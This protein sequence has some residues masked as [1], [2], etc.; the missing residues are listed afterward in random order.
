MM[1]AVILGYLRMNSSGVSGFFMLVIGTEHLKRQEI[2][3]YGMDV[4]R[5]RL[6]GQMGKRRKK[7]LDFTRL[8]HDGILPSYIATI[9]GIG[10]VKRSDVITEVLCYMPE[11]DY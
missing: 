11:E 10:N 8:E 7:H 1:C 9:R 3:Y 2:N 4:H 5:F 6:E